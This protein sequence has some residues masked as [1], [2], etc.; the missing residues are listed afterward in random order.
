MHR[1]LV[2]AITEGD[3]FRAEELWGQVLNIERNLNV[4]YDAA[5]ISGNKDMVKFLW[6]KKNV[7][8]NHYEGAPLVYLCSNLKQKRGTKRQNQLDMVRFLIRSGINVN[9]RGGDP[10]IAAAR[11][12][13]LELLQILVSR[14]GN[15]N[16]QGDHALILA[17]SNGHPEVVEYLLSKGADPNV[18]DGAPIGFAATNGH[19][20]CARMLVEHG[21]NVNINNGVCIELA[22]ENG[23][24]PMVKFLLEQGCSE[25]L[26][27]YEDTFDRVNE[28]A[29]KEG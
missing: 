17:A 1:H 8:V 24:W 16:A 22:E 6:D 5:V 2:R 13:D 15:P 9:A 19:V 28:L 29:S 11:N 27:N 20:A 4:L 23:H 3:V 14:G 26:I 12:G 25:D 21:A 10:C 7:P 18:D